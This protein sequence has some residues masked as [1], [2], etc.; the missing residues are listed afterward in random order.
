MNGFFEISV[1]NLFTELR[2]HYFYIE[3]LLNSQIYRFQGNTIFINIFFL[4]G[5]H[6]SRGSF[7]EL[8]IMKN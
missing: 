6:I 8:F 7:L 5:L 1:N 3:I 4:V 2:S